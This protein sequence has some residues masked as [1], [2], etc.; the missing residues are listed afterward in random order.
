MSEGEKEKEVEEIETELDVV[1]DH[2]TD[3]GHRLMANRVS[4]IKEMLRKLAVTWVD[5]A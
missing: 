4:K 3:F 1:Y 5:H 2:L